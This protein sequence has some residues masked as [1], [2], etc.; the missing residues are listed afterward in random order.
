[1]PSVCHS[2]AHSGCHTVEHDS[3]P[4]CLSCHAIAEAAIARNFIRQPANINAKR[5]LIYKHRSAQTVQGEYIKGLL[6]RS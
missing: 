1:M 4:P 3:F 6:F 2:V 5:W